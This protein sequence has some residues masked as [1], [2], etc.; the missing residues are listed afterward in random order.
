MLFREII[1]VYCENHTQHIDTHVGKTDIKADGTYTYRCT[2]KQPNEIWFRA[3]NQ[4]MQDCVLSE[5]LICNLSPPL[6]RPAAITS[7]H[8]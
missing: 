3:A 6:I 1:A 2:S 8:F 4:E 7:Q 5:M